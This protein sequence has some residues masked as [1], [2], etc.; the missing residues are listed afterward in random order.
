MHGPGNKAGGGWPGRTTQ[1]THLNPKRCPHPCGP[2][3][4]P[5]RPPPPPRRAQPPQR[6]RGDVR[7]CASVCSMHSC[8]AWARGAWVLGCCTTLPV[9]WHIARVVCACMHHGMHSHACTH[10]H[11]HTHT[12][13]AGRWIPFVCPRVQ[14][15]RIGVLCELVVQVCLRV[16]TSPPGCCCWCCYPKS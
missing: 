10:S 2:G 15:R 6:L 4:P 8:E 11:T 16:R 5:C 12:H 7:S 1:H 9:R 3:P 13:K 14:E